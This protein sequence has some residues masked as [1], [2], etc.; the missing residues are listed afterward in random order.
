MK[1]I[2]AG[3]GGVLLSL[4]EAATINITQHCFIVHPELLVWTQTHY[5]KRSFRARVSLG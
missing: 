4:C 3:P 2:A 1:W 5:P